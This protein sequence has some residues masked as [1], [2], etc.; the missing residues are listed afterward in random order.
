MASNNRQKIDE[1]VLGV[2]DGHDAGAVLLRKD[3]ILCAVNEERLTRRKLEVGFPAKAILHCLEIARI[4]PEEI[5]YIASSTTDLAKTLTRLFSTL[6]ENYYQT[7]RRKK[8]PF[9]GERQKMIKYWLT[10]YGP[11]WLTK[12]LSHIL[13]KRECKKLGFINFKLKNFNHHLSHAACAGFASGFDDAIVITLDGLGDGLSGTINVFC[14]GKIE[15]KDKIRAEDSLGIFFEHV[16]YLLG[17]RELEDEGKVMAMADFSYPIEKRNNLFM[18]FFEVSNCNIKA[19]YGPIAMFYELKK[20]LWKTPREQ[21]AKMAQDTL[22]ECVVSLFLQAQKK[23]K[24]KNIAFAGG[25]AANIKINQQLRKLNQIENL[26]VFPHMGDGGLAMGSAFLL[27]K[28]IFNVKQYNFDN[29]YLGKEWEEKDILSALEKN[30][31]NIAWTKV[32]DIAKTTAE[33]LYQDQIVFWF[34]GRAE[35]GPRAL[36]NRSIL[37]SAI[38]LKVKDELNLKVKQRDSFQPFCPSIL[39]EDAEELLI[40][41][42]G[43]K[44]KYMTNAYMATEQAQDKFKVV[45]NVDGSMRAQIVS[46]QDNPLYWQML[47]EVKKLIGRGIVLDTS[48]NI[49][50][51]PMVY[52]PQEAID[53]LLRTR[54]RYLALGDYLVINKKV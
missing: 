40:D 7:R 44:D 51:K 21:F 33:L 45:T 19:K 12:F 11:D 22:A 34:G 43:F 32:N 50:G 17:M 29:I 24:K 46:R 10:L 23:Y 13:I 8:M 26:F 31:N 27:N 3:K 28:E 42:D 47:K 14:K 25:L 49:H 30:K 37:A 2:W 54:C 38:S 15:V 4:K 52:S 20:I 18:D 9:F 41:F 35:Y 48:Y 36:G 53:V 6:K 1:L 5:K 39:E 16:T